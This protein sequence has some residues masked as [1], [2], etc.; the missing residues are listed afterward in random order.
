MDCLAITRVAQR[1]FGI[2]LTGQLFR[3][4][5]MQGSTSRNQLSHAGGAVNLDFDFTFVV[6]GQNGRLA[7]GH[8]FSS[9][10]TT[11][12]PFAWAISAN[13]KT[14]VGANTH[15]SFQMTIMSPDQIEM[16]YSNTGLSDDGSIVATCYMMGRTKQ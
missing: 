11:H 8:S 4:I 6:D 16:C 12:V 7:W 2:R 3:E 13:N 1:L 9:V 14:I 15:G 10:S 5:E